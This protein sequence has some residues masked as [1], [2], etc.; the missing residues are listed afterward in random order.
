MKIWLLGSQGMLGQSL[1]LFLEKKHNLLATNRSQADI[2]DKNNLLN[3]FEDFQPDVVVNATAYTN[4]EKAEEEVDKA[5][6]VN[7][8]GVKNLVDLLKNTD[9][10][11]VHFSTDY[12]FDGKE[13]D[14][15]K[16]DS[17]AFGPLNVYGESKL[18][19][20]KYIIDNLEKYFLIR[21][22]WLYGN[23]GKNFVKTMLSLA[24][25]MPEL[26]VVNDQIG[27]PTNADDLVKM[28]V[29]LLNG[30]YDYGI[31]H[32]VNNIKNSK[33][34]SWYNFACKIF[35]LSDIKIKVTAV[36]S[37]EFPTKAERPAYSILLNTKFN[38]LRDWDVAL[39]NYLEKY[40]R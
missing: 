28:V 36:D 15:Y 35:E 7:H 11:F 32:G 6:A 10:K 25:K 38:K 24:E 30:K 22:S 14:G 12:V 19:G 8:Q 17:Q 3:I 34:V 18:A 39:K 37:G 33:W 2:L 5:W 29:E 31:Y 26:K 27:C 4:V 21:T 16:E 1:K 9:V 20:E 40:E 13:S 23:Y